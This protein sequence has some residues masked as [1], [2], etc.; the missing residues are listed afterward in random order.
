MPRI[1]VSEARISEIITNDVRRPS[2]LMEHMNLME[3]RLILCEF[4]SG[5][6]DLLFRL[7]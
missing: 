3:K 6:G 7:T 4:T 2:I 1:S 5:I